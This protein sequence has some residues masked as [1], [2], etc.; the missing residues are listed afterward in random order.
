MDTVVG[1]GKA[2]CAIADN[3]AQYPQYKTYK[4]DV[5]LVPSPTTFGIEEARNIE[6][7][8][9]NCPDV[10]QFLIDVAGDVLF[11]VGGGGKASLA[12]LAILEHLKHCNI[13]ILYI[14]PE[15]DF[16]GAQG[17]LINNLVFNVF[18]EYA[19][20][21]VFHRLY[22]ID[23][24][25]VERAI[26]PTSLKNYYLNLNDAIVSS[27]HMINVFSHISSV[28]DTFADLP[29]ATRISTIGFVD[30]KKNT[31]KMFFS[32]DNVTDRVY[33]YACNK[34][35]LET[36]NNLFGEI[37]NSLKRKMEPGVR[38]SYGIF[39]TDYE[40]DYIYC[41]NHTSVIQGQTEVG[42]SE[43]LPTSP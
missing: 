43:D 31:D 10:S 18:Q 41:V 12:S 28:T 19:R 22:L 39:E 16:L 36:E 32:L 9:K 2:G 11:V 20:S 29:L 23:N 38:V 27:L 37:K 6:E 24:T 8:E 26:P 21:G 42:G 35:R 1:L 5:G 3:F 4:I 30:P 7:Y 17:K 14:Q 40:E 34:M 25:L 33:Y 13:N 15:E